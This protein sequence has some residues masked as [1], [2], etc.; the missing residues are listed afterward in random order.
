L[1][2]NFN[3]N[4]DISSWTEVE[5][6]KSN[7]PNSIYFYLKKDLSLEESYKA[8]E[9]HR[10]KLPFRDKTNTPSNLAYWIKKGFSEEEAKQK[11]SETQGTR[12]SKKYKID[13][14][15]EEVGL[16]K[17]SAA[18]AKRLSTRINNI[19]KENNCTFEEAYTIFCQTMHN[20]SPRTVGYWMG[21]GLTEEEAREKVSEFQKS[22]CIDTFMKKGL[23]TE[24]A[25]SKQKE[26]F[27]KIEK[28]KLEK[29]LMIPLENREEFL[30]YKKDA[31]ALSRVIFRKNKSTIDPEGLNDN[32]GYSVDHKFSIFHGFIN[33]VPLEIISCVY[34]LRVIPLKENSTKLISSCI[35]LQELMN[36]YNENCS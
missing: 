9:G 15:G 5:K 19:Q 33:K 2:T 32:P 20:Y 31:H 29:G 16:E 36:L 8:L 26:T 23:T 18:G 35:S 21:R 1:N 12:G 25:L 4:T 28:T 22:L 14:Y 6:R 7:S 11:V 27:Q 10:S 24:Q 34:N 3:I 13:K 17:H 30:Q